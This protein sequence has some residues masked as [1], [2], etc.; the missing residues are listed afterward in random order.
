MTSQQR[1]Q[2][3]RHLHDNAKLSVDTLAA[4]IDEDPEE[5]R[6]AIA[7]WEQAGIIR[8]YSAVIH[9][10]RVDEDRVRGIIEVKVTPQRGVGFDAV[11][12]RIYQFPE[13]KD[14]VLVSGSYDLQVIVEGHRIQDVARFV[15][16]RL[17]TIEHVQSTTTHFVL[18]TYKVDGII[19]DDM[20]GDQRLVV[21]P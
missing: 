16:E 19:M 5:V 7:E 2:L 18:K 12:R 11:A 21:S 17:A 6:A 20:D 9:W 1:Q 14:V 8:G 4:M 13:V 3:L 10:D 15:A